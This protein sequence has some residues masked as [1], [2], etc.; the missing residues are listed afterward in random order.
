MGETSDSRTTDRRTVLKMAA[1]G[2]LATS[3]G[4]LEFTEDGGGDLPDL[5]DQSDPD[6][7]WNVDDVQMGGEF[8]GTI[9]ANINAFDPPSISDTTS[10]KTTDL[11][12]EGL[13]V[14]DYDLEVVPCLASDW[15]QVDDLTYEFSLREG[16]QFHNGDE[17]TAEDVQVSLE[18]FEESARHADVYDW[19]ESSEI[20]D[21]YTIRLTLWRQFAPFL[22]NLAGIPITPAAAVDGDVDLSTNPVGT[23]P[24]V[25]EEYRE[26]DLF[27]VSRNEDYWFEETDQ[28]PGVAPIETVTLR[29]ITEQSAQISALRGGD[30]DMINNIDPE[31]IASLQNDD[32][33]TVT[34]T[35]SP[36][37]DMLIYPMQVGPFQ[38][39][40]IRR[41]IT[42]L[43]P[44]ESITQDVVFH[45]HAQPAAHPI[46]PALTDQYYDEEFT[47]EMRDE[48]VG[49]NE[50]RAM[51]LLEEGFEE[52]GVEQPYQVEI[53]SNENPVRVQ[54]AQVIQNRLNET[55][56]FDVSLEEIEWATYVDLVLGE[57]SQER[58]QLVALGWSG[59]SDPN[60]QVNLLFNSEYHTPGCCNVN[61]YANQ[62]VDQL[63]AQGVETTDPDERSDIYLDLSEVLCRDSPMAF[64]WYNFA[65]DAIR[66]ERITNWRTAPIDSWETRAIY[67]PQIGQTAWLE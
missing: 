31:D 63:I 23:G 12:Y 21:D 3:A 14:M 47:E 45:G 66:S 7:D 67:T 36:G 4:C 5:E 59:G 55:D 17:L 8:I 52:A 20:V 16:V 9:G 39:E 37:Y 13:T 29:I 1:A 54:W 6:L 32:Q 50:D 42:R 25:F 10:A 28:L 19:Y 41:G 40:K 26:D 30:V 18:R 57:G 58:E 22:S 46:S 53:I 44:R 27:R 48:Y 11:V 60:Y 15:E 61:H 34:Q 35:F 38:N 51:E 56:Y 49:Q 62:E 24:Y 33:F 2:G 43:I 65:T 64:L